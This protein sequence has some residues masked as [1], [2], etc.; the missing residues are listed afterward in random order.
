M[1]LT[2]QAPGYTPELIHADPSGSTSPLEI[3]LKP[4][5]AVQGRVVDESGKPLQDISVSV[6]NWLGYRSRLNVTTKTDT[7]GK[8]RLTDAPPS[9]V[10]Y[11][12]SK[13]GYMWVHDFPM[14]PQPSGQS[15]KE[16]YLVTLKSPLRVAG[17][18]VDAQTKQPLVRCTVIKGVEFDDGRAPAWQRVVST[19]TIT[20]GRY[21]FEFAGGVFCWRVRVEA[22]GYMPAVSRIFKPGDLDKGRVTYDFKLSKAAPL[23]G[24]VLGPDGKPLTN[25]EV[26]LATNL[27]VVNDGKA[28]SQSLRNA[29]MA[30]TDAAGRF[31]LP[32]EV[33]PFYLVVLHD[34]GYAVISEAQF[35]GSADIR[36][37][38]WT[39]ENRSF[40]AERRPSTHPGKSP[41]ANAKHALTVRVVDVDGKP[42]EG[43][44]VATYA[45]FHVSPNQFVPY[46]SGWTYS[47]NILSDG[48][49]KARIAD[50][51]NRCVVA[52]HVERKLVAVR[53]ISPEQING[54]DAVTLTMHPQ[55]T[56]SG[57]LTSKALEARNRKPT[58]SNVYVYLDDGI[59]RPMSCMSDDYHFGNSGILVDEGY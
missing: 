55:C 17:S 5:Q 57:K 13:K 20:G 19:K 9:D 51:Y 59:G 22:E 43:A 34:Q 1:A 37:K 42:V 15:G 45:G 56:V 28:S 10:L 12:F 7:D 36:I 18:I 25:A 6:S 46:E 58:F 30:R 53:S 21:E 3:T 35:V 14:S 11:D 24:I 38:P 40:R 8:F 47:P 33:E 41:A 49:G 31:E 2:V 27:L 44:H 4:G 39:A 23:T 52:R 50:P 32:P 29:R 54:A 26:F 16:G 48:D